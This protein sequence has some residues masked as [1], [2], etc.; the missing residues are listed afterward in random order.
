MS[1]RVD[2][3]KGYV[4]LFE[5]EKQMQELLRLRR[6]LCLLNAKRTRLQEFRRN[7]RGIFRAAIGTRNITITEQPRPQKP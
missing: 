7:R 6:A 3:S 4:S 1:V 2:A 5:L